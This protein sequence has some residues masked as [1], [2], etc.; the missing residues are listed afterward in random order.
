[1]KDWDVAEGER[2][3][4]KMNPKLLACTTRQTGMQILRRGSPGRGMSLVLE[5][6]C[7]KLRDFQEEM[8]TGGTDIC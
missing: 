2:G 7:L 1:M 6:R 3:A 4:S 8:V 5:S